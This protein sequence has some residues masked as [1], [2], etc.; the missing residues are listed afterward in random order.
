VFCVVHWYCR[1]NDPRYGKVLEITTAQ[2]FADQENTLRRKRY[3][4]K[5]KTEEPHTGPTSGSRSLFRLRSGRLLPGQPGHLSGCGLPGL[6][7]LPLLP[8][9]ADFRLGG[10]SGW[11]ASP[12]TARLGRCTSWA[13]RRPTRPTRASTGRVAPRLVRS[14]VAASDCCAPYAPARPAL[15]KV[16]SCQLPCKMTGSNSPTTM[17]PAASPREDQDRL[18]SFTHEL[19]PTIRSIKAEHRIPC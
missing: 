13:G 1:G 19:F 8:G 9:W 15:G 18:G 17:H 4:E 14:S 7:R 10:P 12:S 3:E 5:K 16:A 11:P 2:H 6:L